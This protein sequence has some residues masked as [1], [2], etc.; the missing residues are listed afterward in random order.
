MKTKIWV[1][2]VWFIAMILLPGLH[3]EA[4]VFTGGG[5][6]GGVT[7]NGFYAD[8]SPVV[9]YKYK[10]MR[11]GVSPFLS[12]IE[13]GPDDYILMYGGRIFIQADIYKGIFAHG[14]FEAINHE[15]TRY[16]SLGD[17]VQ[18]R[19]WDLALPLGV[20]YSYPLGENTVAYGM[21]LWNVIKNDEYP[22]KNPIFRAGIRYS[23]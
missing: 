22:Q 6:G 15:V 3:A 13:R 23:L 8:L 1:V 5:L 19:K 21:I 10:I 11:A 18:K 20:G 9:G 14:E 2:S 17:A 12:L 4:Q 7:E 16:N